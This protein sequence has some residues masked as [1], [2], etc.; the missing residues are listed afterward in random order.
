MN[1]TNESCPHS[2]SIGSL[3]T[4][5][6]LMMIA[7]KE[8]SADMK[9]V[10]LAVSDIAKLEQAQGYDRRAVD[11]LAKKVEKLEKDCDEYRELVTEFKG[12]KRLLQILWTVGG[13]GLGIALFKLF[14]TT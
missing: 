1:I 6:E 5:I 13:S 8:L 4:H 7:M 14:G 10:R 2:A 3:E 9:A 11:D 12:M